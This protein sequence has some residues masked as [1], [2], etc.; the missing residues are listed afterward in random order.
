MTIFKD[1]INETN[2]S[3]VWDCF[4]R[5]YKTETEKS[6]LEYKNFYKKLRDIVPV[7]NKDN[8]AIYISAFKDDKDGE[9]VY[10][11]E[12]YENDKELYFDVGGI[13][14]AGQV[15]GIEGCKF[16]TWLGLKID[17]ETLSKMS[18][19]NIIAHCIWE[20]SFFGLERKETENGIILD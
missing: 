11:E 18:T 17:T 7:E 1:L 6:Y 16:S 3:D 19:P 12:Y 8:L 15:Y 2:F 9:A 4:I 5:H 14:K 20:M 13:D 10:Q